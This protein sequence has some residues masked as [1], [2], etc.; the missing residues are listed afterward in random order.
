MFVFRP[1]ARLLKAYA[2]ACALFLFVLGVL[3]IEN[4]NVVPELPFAIRGGE[5]QVDGSVVLRNPD[6]HLVAVHFDGSWHPAAASSVS[7]RL[8]KLPVG[9]EVK[10]RVG[11]GTVLTARVSGRPRTAQEKFKFG[12]LSFLALS[13]GLSALVIA[14]AASDRTALYAAAALGGI[15]T[16]ASQFLQ[17]A[18]MALSSGT[19]RDVLQLAW[20]FLPRPLGVAFALT[21]ALTF[22]IRTRPRGALR[23]ATAATELFVVGWWITE[24]AGYAIGLAAVAP[25]HVEPLL[26]NLLESQ[27]VDLVA[28]AFAPLVIFFAVVSQARAMRRS[29]LAPDVRRHASLVGRGVGLGFG[30]SFSV[31]VLQAIWLLTTGRVLIPRTMVALSL[32]PLLL[33]PATITYAMLAPRAASIGLR[34]RRSGM[35]L[36][37]RI[38]IRTLTA[39]PA[40]ALALVLWSNRSRT[41]AEILGRNGIA[42]GAL[43]VLTFVAIHYADR[44]FRSTD[45]L[46]LG[47]RTQMYAILKRL[48]STSGSIQNRH[49]LA[50]LLENE[51]ERALHLESIAVLLRDEREGTFVGKGFSIEPTSHVAAACESAATV[52]VDEALLGISSEYERHWLDENRVALLVPI[53]GSD[54]APSGIIALGEMRSGARFDAR[55]FDLLAAVASSAGLALENMTLRS[56]S[57]GRSHRIDAVVAISGD[58]PEI[59]RYCPACRGVFSHAMISCLSDEVAT[60]ATGVPL[61]IAGKYLLESRIGQGG[62]GVV[63]RARDLALGRTVA[64]KT[65]PRISVSAA[66]RLRQEARS[67]AAVGHRN[68][69]LI[70]ATESWRGAPMLIL[71]YLSGGTIADRLFSGPLPV[72]EVQETAVAIASALA[73]AHR[74]G[75]LHRDIKPSNIGYGPDSLPKLLDFGLARML[76]D[77]ISEVSAG[78]DDPSN[79]DD[80]RTSITNGIVGTP[81]YLAPEVIVGGAASE[82][83]DLWALSVTLYEALAGVHPLRGGNATRTMNR[84]LNEEF[85]DVR[86]LRPDCPG[87]LAQFLAVALSRTPSARPAT[88]SE[89]LERLNAK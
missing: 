61:V 79:G 73:E 38:V 5:R 46:L 41:I 35:H 9:S 56:S 66:S 55:H 76:E 67:T 86:E 81:A 70:Y 78:S 71:E 12:V 32:L 88:A 43:V 80:S 17:P 2:V 36:F 44:L 77:S 16:L 18:Q 87:D 4:Y 68:L 11:D 74:R 27:V 69:A 82:G 42:I 23:V 60:V 85:P 89:Y 3:A 51:I 50:T 84:I 1:S 22:P 34:V 26:T 64:V 72:A 7:L 83:A 65:L 21:L 39:V 33:V 75:I 54:A 57:S 6:R 52:S 28:Y 37:L 49:D 19:A 25:L 14:L 15:G 58:E 10:Y 31:V 24:A 53:R 47:D 40:V 62:M 29:D 13:F 45:R 20:M 30:L 8:S 63:Y 59:A 48:A